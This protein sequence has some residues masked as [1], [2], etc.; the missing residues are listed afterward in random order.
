M[1]TFRPLSQGHCMSRVDDILVSKAMLHMAQPERV[2]ESS[3]DSDHSPVFCTFDIRALQVQLPLPI[4][5]RPRDSRLKTPVDKQSLS[6]FKSW[7]SNELAS[8][9]CHTHQ[10]ICHV[11][12]RAEQ[13]CSTQ[14]CITGH[15]TAHILAQH[16]LTKETVR[17][18]A[19]AITDLLIGVGGAMS[20]ARETLEFTAPTMAPEKVYLRGTAGHKLQKLR[21]ASRTQKAAVCEF[22][23]V[24]EHADFGQKLTHSLAKVRQ[25]LEESPQPL[26]PA[27]PVPHLGSEEVVDGSWLQWHADSLQGLRIRRT[28]RRIL[29]KGDISHKI[30]LARQRFQQTFATKRKLANKIIMGQMSM[31]EITCLLGN[32]ENKVYGAPALQ[33]VAHEYF[34]SLATATT[35]KTGTFKAYLIAACHG[36]TRTWMAMPSRHGLGIHAMAQ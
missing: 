30:K 27:P 10:Q 7:A 16:A 4:P 26:P 6:R 11:R 9:I 32:N 29:Q 24:A 17:D 19:S 22:E 20:I 8:R 18:Q 15:A 21:H 2:L 5:S 1:H 12:T 35:S 3:D 36:P 33:A 13:I 34:Q 28:Q 25:K 23:H 31:S 14:N